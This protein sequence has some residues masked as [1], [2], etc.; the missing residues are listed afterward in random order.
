V[1]S[2]FGVGSGFETWLAESDGDRADRM[3]QLQDMYQRWPFFRTVIGNVHLGLGRADMEISKGYAELAGDQA[4]KTIHAQIQEEYELSKSLI[5]EIT[6]DDE[7]LDTEPWLQKSIRVRNPYVDPMN[8]IQV[9]LLKRFRSSTEEDDTETLAQA[10]LQSVNG[11][12]AGLQSV[13]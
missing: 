10:I 4:G 9:E 6:G 2:W 13:G 5:L 12:A 7:L 1:P 3:K 8:R 11:I